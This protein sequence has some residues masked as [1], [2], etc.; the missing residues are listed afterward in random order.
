MIVLAAFALTGCLAVSAGSD[1]VVAGD[2]APAF[3]GLENVAAD[4]VLAFAPA[5]GVA[6]VFRVQELRR[7]AERFQLPE[8]PEG[9]LCVA[10]PVKVLD[11]ALLLAA[12]HQELPEA[13]IE[14][15]EFSRLPA[16]EGQI[17]FHKSD[18]R[19]SLSG[20]LWTGC[21]RYAGNRRFT[22]WARVK[23]LV[24][25]Q[26]VMAV[27]DLRQGLPIPE[28]AVL[29]ESRDEYPAA[30]KF[31]ESVAEVVGKWPRV[32]IRAGTAI[33]MESIE[34]P[35]DVMRGETV[36]VNVHDGS[37]HLEFEARA[38]GSGFAGQTISVSNP[39]SH[40]RFLA[41]VDGKGRVSVG[42]PDNKVHP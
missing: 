1:H 28:T 2:L 10:R 37:A 25:T 30:G 33:R 23:V 14:I 13:A 31:A 20:S 29:A 8:A 3:P 34:P 19:Y 4:T 39:L 6:R 42:N 41:R 7:L 18:L 21:V 36:Q 9:E 17:E 12:M 24:K 22:I 40:K 35:K 15:L 16:P 5:P 32:P 27:T 38:E 26:R 11:G